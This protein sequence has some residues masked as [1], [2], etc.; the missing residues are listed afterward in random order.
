MAAGSRIHFLDTLPPLTTSVMQKNRDF[1]GKE[2]NSIQE[3]VAKLAAELGASLILTGDGKSKWMRLGPS[4]GI[5]L[6]MDTKR[7]TLKV[8][9]RPI[10]ASRGQGPHDSPQGNIKSSFLRKTTK[11]IKLQERCPHRGLILTHI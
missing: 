1:L 5:R 11:L 6:V 8:W 7:L 2:G 3:L 10:S 9:H 4:D